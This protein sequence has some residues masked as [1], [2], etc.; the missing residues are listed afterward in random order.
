MRPIILKINLPTGKGK[1]RFLRG[2]RITVGDA[3]YARLVPQ[4]AHDSDELL[5][6]DK[7]RKEA[8]EKTPEGKAAVKL[9]KAAQKERHD[10]VIALHAARDKAA[11]LE[12]AAEEKRVAARLEKILANERLAAE[13]KK[14]HDTAVLKALD[15]QDGN[16]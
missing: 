5:A 13:A 8:Y 1:Q 4:F 12:A 15:P 9:F 16:K 11:K 14:A 2:Q 3:D 6:A 7:A 10:N